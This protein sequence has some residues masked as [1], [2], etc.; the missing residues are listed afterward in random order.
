MVRQD[1]LSRKESCSVLI[2]THHIDDVE[3]ISD[4][5]WF[6]NNQTLVFDGP[7]SDMKQSFHRGVVDSR[8]DRPQCHLDFVDFSTSNPAVKEMFLE[9]FGHVVTVLDG[10]S[11]LHSCRT[12][13]VN[14][15]GPEQTTN[16]AFRSFL[17]NEFHRPMCMIR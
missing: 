2:S 10:E 16:L 15:S 14:L 8:K 4:R 12:W 3:V 7:I 1:I 11:S 13:S 5:V 17:Q 6:L 9:R